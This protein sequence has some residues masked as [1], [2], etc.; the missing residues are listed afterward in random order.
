MFLLSLILDT[1]SFVWLNIPQLLQQGHVMLKKIVGNN[2]FWAYFNAH[3][4]IILGYESFQ[5][6]ARFYRN[7][8]YLK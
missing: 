7:I 1:F 2:N 8:L 6:Q 5:V 3:T 4:V